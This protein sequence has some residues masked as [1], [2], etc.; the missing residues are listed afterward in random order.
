MIVPNSVYLSLF[1]FFLPFLVI[2]KRNYL[3]QVR[4]LNTER[5]SL[6][7]TQDMFLDP[8]FVNF[9]NGSQNS[10]SLNVTN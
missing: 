9:F 7:L 8:L 3:E 2:F 1:F 4:I 5:N 6:V 10:V